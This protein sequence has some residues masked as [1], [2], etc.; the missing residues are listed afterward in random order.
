MTL[1]HS[2]LFKFFAVQIIKHYSLFLQDSEKALR[3]ELGIPSDDELPDELPAD[4]PSFLAE[5]RCV[6]V[7]N[8][9]ITKLSTP[10]HTQIATNKQS[11]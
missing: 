10:A 9:P 6:F 1:E 8:I 11:W 7:A 3:R 4:I 2:L 5:R